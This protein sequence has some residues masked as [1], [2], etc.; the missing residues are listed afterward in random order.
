MR[1]LAKT[2]L[3]TILATFILLPAAAMAQQ[4]GGKAT[5]KVTASA[6]PTAKKPVKRRWRGY[7]FLPGYRQ[8]PALTDWR[9]QNRRSTAHERYEPRYVYYR[10]YSGYGQLR[11]GWGYPGTYRGRWN[12][13]SFGP[14]WTQ[15][16]IGMVWNCGE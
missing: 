6:K 3:L 7:G 1:P 13:G 4:G 2:L 5:A 9:A 15:T 16:P 8:P 12:G 14:C 10:P 11:Y